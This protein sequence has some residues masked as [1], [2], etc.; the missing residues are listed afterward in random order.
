MVARQELVTLRSKYR[1][2]MYVQLQKGESVLD[3]ELFDQEKIIV[4]LTIKEKVTQ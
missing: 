3:T 4:C 1:E 2:N